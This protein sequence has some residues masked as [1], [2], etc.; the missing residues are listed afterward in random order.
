M[1]SSESLASYPDLFA[2]VD[3]KQRIYSKKTTSFRVPFDFRQTY[4]RV[5]TNP[6]VPEKAATPIGLP[7]AEFDAQAEAD[8]IVLK[9][10]AP[11]GVIVNSRTSPEASV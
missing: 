7:V 9:S 1:G 8:R 6:K 5:E 3:K 2:T 4:Q 11:V 10:H